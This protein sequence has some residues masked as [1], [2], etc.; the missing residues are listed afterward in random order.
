MRSLRRRLEQLEGKTEASVEGSGWYQ[1]YLWMQRH[2]FPVVEN[3]HREQQGLDPLPIPE[4]ESDPEFDAFWERYLKA[5]EKNDPQMI[6][7]IEEWWHRMR[8]ER[9]GIPRRSPSHS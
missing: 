8:W 4:K 1:R 5:H 9:H 6:Q 7:E 2:Y 3:Y